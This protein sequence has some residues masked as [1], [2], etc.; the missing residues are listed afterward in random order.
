MVALVAALLLT[1]AAA[2]GSQ[3]NRV[4]ASA[5]G[6]YGTAGT[7]AGSTFDVRPFSFY[8]EILADG[9]VKGAYDYRQVRDGVELT[10]AGPLTC[11]TIRG[12]QAWVGGKIEESSR[13]NLIGLEMW[14]QV[15]DNGRAN[16]GDAEDEGK[17]PADMTSTIGAGGPGT[18]QKYCDDAPAVLFPFY[19]DR[20][21]LRVNVKAQ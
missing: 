18:G 5:K 21:D 4:V 17:G 14:F 15:Q 10:V 3:G 19:L 6:Y 7:A 1:T 11:A 16:D 2:A 20:G 13:A 12:N 9:R 8:V